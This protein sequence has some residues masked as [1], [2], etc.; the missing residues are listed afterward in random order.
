[1]TADGLQLL[2][3]KSIS[4]WH[5]IQ[6]NIAFSALLRGLSVI[7]QAL[8]GYSENW[9]KQRS[10]LRQQVALLLPGRPLVFAKASYSV[11]AG[12]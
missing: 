1:M 10:A 3:G 4:Y 5:L 7:Q 8:N 9:K 2:A 12:L 6:R 11:F